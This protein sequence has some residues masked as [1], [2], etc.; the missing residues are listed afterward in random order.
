M[1]INDIENNLNNYEADPKRVLN[2]ILNTV[3]F[4]QA[5]LQTVVNNQLIIMKLID[6]N[7]DIDPMAKRMSD[8]TSHYLAQIQADISSE[9]GR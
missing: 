7:I 2:I 1:D 3:V 9:L 4:N 6:K 8:I 5:I